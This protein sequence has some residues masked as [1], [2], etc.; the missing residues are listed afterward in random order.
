MSMESKLNLSPGA[1]E[2]R[3]INQSKSNVRVSRFVERFDE[4]LIDANTIKSAF[5]L[6]YV[7]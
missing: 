5:R 3:I 2:G 7:G 4:S 6:V 1:I